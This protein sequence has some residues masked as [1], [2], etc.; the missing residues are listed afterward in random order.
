[1]RRPLPGAAA[2][3]DRLLALE[4]SCQE[5]GR[6]QLASCGLGPS[7]LSDLAAS[8]TPTTPLRVLDIS[9]NNV[10]RGQLK[11]GR[12]GRQSWHYHSDM[13]GII[14]LARA[15]GGSAAPSCL[16]DVRLSGVCLGEVIG[17]SKSGV[18]ALAGALR[19]TRTVRSLD[20]SSNVLYEAGARILADVLRERC[21]LTELNIERNFITP[22]GKRALGRALLA[23][24]SSCLLALTCDG[25][26]VAPAG[27]RGRRAR[28]LDLR[29]CGVGP[30]ELLLISGVLSNGGG[31]TPAP[32]AR[33]S[34]DADADADAGSESGSGSESESESELKLPAAGSGR[35]AGSANPRAYTALDLSH[36]RIV[37]EGGRRRLDGLQV[38]V[39]CSVVRVWYSVVRVPLTH[40]T[41]CRCGTIS[42][43]L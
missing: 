34:H 25:F 16:V 20:V 41:G 6:L 21:P 17:G 1:M 14:D 9:N 19:A 10:T 5:D 35:G 31:G 3:R 37:W 38:G 24:R 33:G 43:A 32:A 30:A 28:T 4:H 11:E 26:R 23:N 2:V 42:E 22:N 36:N 7:D 18:E 39:C 8:L 40:W 12:D 13:Q 29:G 15:L 27:R